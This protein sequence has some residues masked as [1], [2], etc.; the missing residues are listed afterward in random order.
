MLGHGRRRMA[1]SVGA[2]IENHWNW[3]CR[4]VRGSNVRV[5]G[6]PILPK[7]DRVFASG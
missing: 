2:G 5:F 1:R 7:I 6:A 4:A 3:G